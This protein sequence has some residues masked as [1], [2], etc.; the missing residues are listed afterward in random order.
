MA[1]ILA[2]RDYCQSSAAG[3]IQ[4]IQSFVPSAVTNRAVKP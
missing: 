2:S 1:T 4:V 3:K